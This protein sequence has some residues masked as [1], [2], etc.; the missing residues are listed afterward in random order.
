MTLDTV[1]LDGGITRVNLGGRLDI[2]GAAAIDLRFSAL[3]SGDRPLLLVDLSQV[4]FLASVGIRTFF[5]T[6]RTVK[7]RRGR[8]VLASPT[9]MVAK[10]LESAAVDS[11]I[12]V[13]PDA[14]AACQA[15]QQPA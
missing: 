10:V 11:L 6:A 14:E 12:P 13:F 8:M 3:A 7:L 5:A 2:T 1:E 9:E 4:S 15:L